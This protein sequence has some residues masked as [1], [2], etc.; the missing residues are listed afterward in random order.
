MILHRKVFPKS[1]RRNLRVPTKKRR[2]L[3]GAVIFCITVLARKGEY[4]Q[5]PSSSRNT[6]RDTVMYFIKNIFPAIGVQPFSP[7]F[8]SGSR[9]PPTK[10][11]FCEFNLFVYAA[12]LLIRFRE[13]KS[14]SSYQ[15]TRRLSRAN[16]FAL[17]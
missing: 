9:I 17:I 5:H 4:P 10:K 8:G 3:G 1:Q 16:P 6:F 11:R 15:F 12:D 13:I 14:T 2:P 7:N